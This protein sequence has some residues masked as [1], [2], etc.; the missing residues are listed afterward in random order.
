[1]SNAKKG[2][3]PRKVPLRRCLGC[4]ESFP[5]KDL[6]R[7]VRSPE[8]EVAL[9]FTGKM[10][11]RGAYVCKRSACFQKARKA[12]RF[13]NNLEISISEEVLDVLAHEIRLFEEENA[14]G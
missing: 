11:G 13:Q 12:K 14:D 1:M 2:Q 5:K 7:V 9:D 10:S 6:M 3:K 8:G 4:G